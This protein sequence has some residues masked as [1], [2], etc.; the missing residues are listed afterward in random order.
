MITVKDVWRGAMPDGTE[1]LGGGGG[2]DRRVEWATALRTRPPAFETIKGGEMAFVPVRS[3][4]LLDERLDLAQVIQSFGDK[5]GVAVAVVGEASMESVAVAERMMM[6]LLH[7]P[8]GA[9]LNDIQQTVVRFILDQRTLLHERQQELHTQLMEL[10]LAG[11]G[12][13][14]IVDRLA[15]ITGQAA[16]WQDNDGTVRH[17]SASAD[18]DGLRAGLEKEGPRVRRWAEGIAVVAADP[19]VHEF[20]LHK[21]GMARLVAPVPVRDGI[22]GFISLIAP[23]T[24]LDQL[25]RLA[26]ARAAS[27]C[28]IELDRERAVLQARDELEGEFLESLLAGTYSSESAVRHRAERLGFDVSGDTVVMVAR[29]DGG[30]EQVP[31][32]RG[33]QLVAG[34]QGWIRRRAPAALATLRQRAVA[35]VVPLIDGQPAVDLRRLAADLRLECAGAVG[36]EVSV[37]LGRAKPGIN[38]VRASYR[39]AEQ[40]LTMGTRLFGGA[41]V[42]AFADLGLY[43]LL[44]AMNGQ[45]ELREFFDDQVQALVE[46][47]QRTG[48]GLMATLDAFFRCH[49]SPTEIAQLLHLHRNTVLYRLRR[50]EDIAQLSLDDPETRLNL[51]LCL[52]VRDVLQ[53][54]S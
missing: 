27:A 13:P 2:L 34:A 37:G 23:D 19:P 8:D 3:I 12:T 45:T 33:D 9:H 16:V 10:A 5:G 39:E 54:A 14:A 46:Y 48:A 52:K 15:E 50:I 1:L 41:R 47:D 31:R 44:Y 4:R 43:R 7:L 26:V 53:A 21:S 28:A 49:G 24:Q 42:V 51:H 18:G 30:V 22:G 17:V 25:S 36:G 40:A 29:P 38:G 6:P 32:V 35:A 20:A 11:A